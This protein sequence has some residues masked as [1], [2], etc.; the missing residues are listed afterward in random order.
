[1]E[2]TLGRKPWQVTATRRRKAFFSG[3]A[4]LTGLATFWLGNNLPADLPLLWQALVV[5]PFAFLFFWLAL[6]FMTASAGLWVLNFGGTNRIA[7]SP[8][9]PLPQLQT[10]DTTAILLPIYNE[11]I[12][13][14]YAGLQAIYQSLEKTGHLQHFEFYILSDSDDASNWLREEAAWSNLCRELG[15]TDRIHYRRRK[16]RTKKKSGNVMDFCRRWGKRHPFMVVLDADSL[17]TGDTLVRL[18]DAMDRNERVGLIQTPL[19]NVGLDTLYARG[20][21]LVNRLYGPVFF[22]GLHWWWLG[23]SQYWGHNVIIRTQAFMGH[24]H[25]P[26]LEESGKLGG[27]ILS[28]DFVEAALLNRAGWETWLAYDLDGSFERPPPTMT[29]SLKRDRRWCQG[30]LQHWRIIWSHGVSNLHRFL[31]LNGIVSYVSS[32]IWLSWLLVLTAIAVFYPHLTLI[33]LTA[34]NSALLIMT[35]VLLFFYKTFGLIQAVRKNTIEQF[36]GV[37]GLTASVLTE[38]FLSMLTAPVRMMYYS[39][40]VVQVLRGKRAVWGTQ[41]RTGGG[42]TWGDAVREYGW[43]SLIG[44]AWGLLLLAF[45]PMAFLWMSPVIAGLVLA[46]PLAVLT[47]IQTSLQSPLFRTP[48]EANPDFILQAFEENHSRMLATPCMSTRDLFTR[49]IVDPLAFRQHMTYIPQRSNVPEGT[50]QQR[51]ELVKRLLEQGPGSITNPER[52]VILEDAD[53]LCQLHT[54]VWQLPEAQFDEQWMSKL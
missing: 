16:H 51:E 26:K 21:Q 46:V 49:V 22:A 39:K 48:D 19:Y 35:I 11:D 33:P 1:M 5:I 32:P 34:G 15:S 25:L 37:T 54:Q 12:A 6:G 27:E 44:L 47:S 42:L 43:V 53:M 24:C 14:V 8:S 50:R 31:L 2:Q 23:E 20:Q 4:L 3:I 7:S 29:D 38:T 45:N 36:G 41:Q 9:S 52:L 18:V 10:V 17:M 30:N 28:H 13:Y 40:F